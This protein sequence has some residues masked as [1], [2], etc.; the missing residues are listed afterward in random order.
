MAVSRLRLYDLATEP[1]WSQA[2][3]HV[4][5]DV[6]S[7]SKT[8]NRVQRRLMTCRENGDTGWWGGYA[9]FAFNVTQS[10]PF[11]TLP[12]GSARLIRIDACNH[13]IPISNQ[14]QEFLEFGDGHWPQQFCSDISQCVAGPLSG[15]RR[16]T[17][18]TFTDL[19]TPGNGLRIFV[20]N[21]ADA[22]KRVLVGCTDANGQVIY[23]IDNEVQVNGVFVTL[24]SPF[25][26]VILPETTIPI[27]LGSITAIQKDITL[28]PVS[29][30]QVNLTTGASSLLLTMEPGETVAGY[31]R[32]YLNALP[33]NCCPPP[34]GQTDTVQILGMVKLDLVPAQ[35]YTDYL[36]IQS[37][38]AM[39][40]EAQAARL[41]D[42]DAPTAKQQAAERHR[43]AIRY[44][45]GQLVHFEGKEF[46][47]MKFS[48]FDGESLARQKIGWLV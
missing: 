31:S 25:A 18:P 48:P 7:N 27:E 1:S 12:R 6:Y 34:D 44:L 10:N 14:F 20:A 35:V 41:G 36:L 37:I 26:D 45:Q 3:G 47:A 8:A 15:F 5:G 24:A 38:D 11:I 2:T 46:P 19:A 17:V 23:T 4:P 13:P 22:G 9:Q 16:N 40:A 33:K 42:S 32:Y 39:V 28:G 30:Y 43:E 21:A 29:F